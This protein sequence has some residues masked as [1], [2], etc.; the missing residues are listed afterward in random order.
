MFPLGENFQ[1]RVKMEL[2]IVSRRCSEEKKGNLNRECRSCDIKNRIP[3]EFAAAGELRRGGLR[4][5]SLSGFSARRQLRLPAS[6][7]KHILSGRP[8]SYIAW[9]RART[10]PSGL[11]PETPFRFHTDLTFL[12][13]SHNNH[14]LPLL[15][16]G[17]E[18]TTETEEPES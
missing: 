11:P 9:N 16:L 17:V 3:G 5:F 18:Q 12:K 8:G 2:N 6:V 10:I 13:P 15:A 7:R 1:P 4:T 14:P